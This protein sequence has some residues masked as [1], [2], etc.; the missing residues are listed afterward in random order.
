MSTPETLSDAPHGGAQAVIRLVLVD[1]DALA[2]RGMR[3]TV[4]GGG[5]FVVAGE[6]AHE[7]EAL[8]C[9]RRE[10]PD[11]VLIDIGYPLLDGIATARELRRQ[12]PSTR[13][14]FCSITDDEDTAVRALRAGAVGYVRKDLEYGP[15]SRALRGALAGEAAISRQ[16][17]MRLIEELYR[18]SEP[19]QRLRPAG[20][21]LTTREWQVL[22]LL[23]DGAGTAD[24]AET[25]GLAIE[26]VRSHIKHVLRK[27]GVR[28]RGEAVEIAR[29]LRGRRR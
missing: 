22:D 6:A 15:L 23:I 2:R 24:I 8:A 3:E 1:R 13:I 18:H 10:R 26:T 17:G 12:I 14:V 11:L 5:E 7:S 20:G 29:R 25:L 21:E 19:S 9:V 28:T 16:L 27:L 4:T